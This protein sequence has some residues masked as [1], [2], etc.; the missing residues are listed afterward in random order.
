LASDIQGGAL[1]PIM[2]GFLALNP[3]RMPTRKKGRDKITTVVIKTK[4]A[5]EQRG[6]CQLYISIDVENFHKKLFWEGTASVVYTHRRLAKF[7]GLMIVVKYGAVI[8]REKRFFV[9][10]QLQFPGYG[11]FIANHSAVF[12]HDHQTTEFY[13]TTV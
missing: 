12:N 7:R 9:C 1:R 5:T 10:A 13:Q 8:G 2:R 3:K 6:H 11:F 4:T